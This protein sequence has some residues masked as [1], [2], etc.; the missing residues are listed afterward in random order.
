VTLSVSRCRAYV[1]K[2]KKKYE[3]FKEVKFLGAFSLFNKLKKMQ[4]QDITRVTSMKKGMS[5]MSIRLGDNI[6]EIVI[7]N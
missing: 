3:K 2:Y 5:S 6:E 7:G 4:T 1:S